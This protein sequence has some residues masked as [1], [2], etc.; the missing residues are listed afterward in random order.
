MGTPGVVAAGAS[1]RGCVKSIVA[2]VIVVV[3]ITAGV[4]FVAFKSFSS[5][6]PVFVPSSNVSSSSGSSSSSSGDLKLDPTVI[7][8]V[9]IMHKG[10]DARIPDWQAQKDTTVHHVPVAD[11]G[12]P[13]NFNTKE[14]VYG[15]CTPSQFYVFVLN[16]TR[17]EDTTADSEG[18]EYVPGGNP[19]NC[20][21]T[22]WHIMSS[23][24]AAPDWYFVTIDTSSATAMPS[25]TA[26][27]G[28]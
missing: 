4:I 17:P 16:I 24:N 7:A 22:G 8:D 3:A 25:P 27:N 9:A 15:Y 2:I 13:A 26:V 28:R 10:L 23:E 6:V 14:V 11:A 12:L 1:G 19:S 20:S 5:A 21:P 18:Y